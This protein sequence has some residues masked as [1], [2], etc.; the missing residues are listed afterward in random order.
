MAI[1]ATKIYYA[2]MSDVFKI[3]YAQVLNVDVYENFVADDK[4]KDFLL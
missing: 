2:I 1:Y 3:K 4:V